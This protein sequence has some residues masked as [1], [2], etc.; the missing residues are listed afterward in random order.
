VDQNAVIVSLVGSVTVIVGIVALLVKSFI[1]DKPKTNG[2]GTKQSRDC[3][4]QHQTVLSKI[5]QVQKTLD[6]RQELFAKVERK[7][8]EINLSVH[9]K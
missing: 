7:L 3:W 4:E 5:D 2:N 6:D 8:D 1:A 9:S